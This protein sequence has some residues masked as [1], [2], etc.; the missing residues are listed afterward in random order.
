VGDG[1]L[2]AGGVASYLRRRKDEAGAVLQGH[3]KPF[4]PR[5]GDEQ[6]PNLA[7]DDVGD[8]AF[9]YGLALLIGEEARDEAYGGK[10]SS[11]TPDEKRGP[12]PLL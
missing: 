7:R 3:Q 11:E 10:I 8:G 9:G 6:G 2:A 1:Q 12:L 5:E 4:E